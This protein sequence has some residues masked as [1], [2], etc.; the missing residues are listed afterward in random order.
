MVNLLAHHEPPA[1]GA[2]EYQKIRIC[3]NCELHTTREI[4]LF[5]PC[6]RCG[7]VGGA[8]V[9]VARWKP[10]PLAPWWQFWRK[11][12]RA[13]G[14]WETVARRGDVWATIGTD[15]RA[16]ITNDKGLT[17]EEVDVNELREVLNANF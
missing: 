13:N 1:G 15:G 11:E 17:W 4:S 7:Y 12:E 9:V 6:W 14:R 3:P 2:A 5:V 8:A 16:A 10:A